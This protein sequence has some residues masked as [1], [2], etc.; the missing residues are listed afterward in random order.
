MAF[1]NRNN[2]DTGTENVKIT[3]ERYEEL[4]KACEQLRRLQE[5][6]KNGERLIILRSD[7]LRLQLDS[8]E[9][10]RLRGLEA[11]YQYSTLNEMQAKLDLIEKQCEYWQKQATSAQSQLK[12]A[13]QNATKWHEAYDELNR[14]IDQQIE[15]GRLSAA[16][17]D[18]LELKQL[19]EQ[20]RKEAD[21]KITEAAAM[22]DQKIREAQKQLS[23]ATQRQKNAA[24]R[25]QEAQAI[26][27]SYEARET[28]LKA[29]EQN[30]M[31]REQAIS[32]KLASAQ[33][34][35]R[36]MRER[37]NAARGIVPKKSHDGYLVL[38]SRQWIERYPA[39]VSG[40]KMQCSTAVW[41][42]VLETPYDVA[43]VADQIGKQIENDLR[44]IVN[45]IGCHCMVSDKDNGRY[46]ISM[47]KIENSRE[48]NILYKWDFVAN[49]RSCF[50]QL[51]IYTTQGLTVPESRRLQQKQRYTS[52]KKHG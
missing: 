51:E 23:I 16:R 6:V 12:E 29:R 9:A 38:S 22:A 20:L 44:T 40:K 32:G 3:R 35:Y 7:Y 36:I 39:V 13:A 14:N 45:D 1:W 5:E 37:A 28:A 34:V 21:N 49:F 18:A 48:K 52:E 30:V 17:Q 50:W 10:E 15:Q 43:L 47:E 4:E 24:Q 27:I 31:E 2:D 8:E 11:T 33:N 46:K 42:S 26:E 41:K 19:E 25:L